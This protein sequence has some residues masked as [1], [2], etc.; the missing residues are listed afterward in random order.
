MSAEAKSLKLVLNQYCGCSG[1]SINVSKSSIHFNKNTAPSV[2][3]SIRAIFPFTKALNS[4]KYLGLP[5]LF[6]KSKTVTFTDI[7]ENVS[8]KI[9]G[10]HAK[11]LSQAGRTVL[12]RSVAST[13]PSYAMS[14]F[15]LPIS[16]SYSLDR[17]FKNF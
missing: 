15:L 9:E 2:I 10:W 16:I 13:I 7:L 4:S 8:G 17:L 14:S 1:Q 5:L 3:Q 12:I 11:T 6:G